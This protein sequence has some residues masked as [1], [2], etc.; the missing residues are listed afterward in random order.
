MWSSCRDFKVPKN[1]ML[2]K[3]DSGLFIYHWLARSNNHCI[4]EC[5]I[6]SFQSSHTFSNLLLVFELSR[7]CSAECSCLSQKDFL[8]VLFFC[9]LF[10]SLLNFSLQYLLMAFTKVQV[11]ANLFTSPG[12]SVVLWFWYF[13][14]FHESPL[15]FGIVP[16]APVIIG[17]HSVSFL[18]L[19]LFL[20]L[21]L[22]FI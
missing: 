22:V 15:F 14:S 16:S 12:I 21:V 13:L 5:A 6:M 1:R 19:D 10:Y 9:F 3:S 8:T 11:T 2:F 7:F 20:Y 4:H 18:W 17:I